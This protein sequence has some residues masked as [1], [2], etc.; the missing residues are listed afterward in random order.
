MQRQPQAEREFQDR[1]DD[2]VEHGVEDGQP[3]DAVAPQILVVF[4]A[5]EDAG[6]ADPRIGKAEPDAEP[7]RIGQKDQQKHR[8]RQ[9]EDQAERRCGFRCMRE[10]SEATRMGGAGARPGVMDTIQMAPLELL[11]MAAEMIPA[12]RQAMV[13]GSAFAAA[14]ELG[15]SALDA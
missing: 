15:V 13:P 11:V 6:P 7:E 4:Q 9:H 3:E 8:R 10:S 5:D 12:R 1:S 2:R 14:A